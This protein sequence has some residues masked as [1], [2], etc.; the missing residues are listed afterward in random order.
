MVW[1][2]RVEVSSFTAEATVVSWRGA[3][4]EPGAGWPK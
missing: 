3:L 4:L 2:Q 1:F